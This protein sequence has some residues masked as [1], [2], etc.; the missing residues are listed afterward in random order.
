VSL[1]LATV[2]ACPP[3]TSPPTTTCARVTSRNLDELDKLSHLYL[4]SHLDFDVP[5]GGNTP[6]V[7]RTWGIAKGD[8]DGSIFIYE[9][10]FPGAVVAPPNVDQRV[11]RGDLLFQG[12]EA[13]VDFTPQP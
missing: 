13:V 3:S 5:R 7:M 11:S 12:A 8:G 10:L 6:E 9:R 1:P 2:G 4:A